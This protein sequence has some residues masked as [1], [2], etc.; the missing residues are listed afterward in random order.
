MSSDMSSDRRIQSSRANGRLSK[1]P[2]TAAGKQRSSQNALC[3][4]LLSRCLVLDTESPEAFQE[5]LDSHI[6]RLQP[7]DGLELGIVEEM[8]AST[9]RLRRSWAVETRTIDSAVDPLPGTDA[10][11]RMTDGFN[12]GA[13]T[14]GLPLTHRYETR[15]HM[16]FRRGLRN[17]LLLRSAI[18]LPADP[19]PAP[20]PAADD[21]PC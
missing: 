12:A 14:A 18:P 8:A 4:G 15:L 19:A 3:H 10:I 2:V 11:G 6:E 13:G 21:L 7:A 1:G 17:L 5:L 20:S 9:W 16:M